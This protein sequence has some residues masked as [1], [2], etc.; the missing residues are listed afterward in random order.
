MLPRNKKKVERIK[1]LEAQLLEE[2]SMRIFYNT[3]YT[4]H[5]RAL[6]LMAIDLQKQIKNCPGQIGYHPKIEFPDGHEN[7]DHIGC[8]EKQFIEIARLQLCTELRA[9]IQKEGNSENGLT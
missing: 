9:K 1:Q 3:L 4:L 7:T 6:R 2:Q 5:E 8:W